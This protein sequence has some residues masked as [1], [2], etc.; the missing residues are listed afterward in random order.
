M[1]LLLR[2]RPFASI[3]CVH[4]LSTA[5]HWIHR[6]LPL[7]M[8]V[9]VCVCVC[10]LNPFEFTMEIKYAIFLSAWIVILKLCLFMDLTAN[11]LLVL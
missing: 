9:C 5:S 4:A 7:C 1:L 8:L 11:S 3:I 6:F 2:E 10:G